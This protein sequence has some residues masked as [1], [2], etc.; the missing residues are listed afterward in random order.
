M[1]IGMEVEAGSWRGDS[2]SAAGVGSAIHIAEAIPRGE[3]V[4]ASGD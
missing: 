3:P 4:V 1:C 2:S